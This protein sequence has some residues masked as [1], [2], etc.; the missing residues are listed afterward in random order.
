M[1]HSDRDLNLSLFFSFIKYVNF[2]Q[3]IDKKR[4]SKKSEKYWFFINF[5][6][7]YD[8]KRCKNE[9]FINYVRPRGEQKSRRNP[10]K[11]P[12]NHFCLI[13]TATFQ[14]IC[15]KM[16]IFWPKSAQK[17]INFQSI[18]IKKAF[19]KHRFL[20]HF[21]LKKNVFI[22]LLGHFFLT[23]WSHFSIKKSIFSF[24]KSVN[25]DLKITIFS[26]FFQFLINF[27]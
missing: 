10:R 26:I 5:L 19:K 6:V 24:I 11:D 22:G 13:N 4:G 3:K 1:S 21:W 7:I 14:S 18:F 8:K 25:F 27:L 9:L 20:A 16:T 17:V 12:E 23:D 15:Y 2:Y